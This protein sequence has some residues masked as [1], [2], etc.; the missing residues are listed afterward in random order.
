[1]SYFISHG[2]PTLAIENNDYTQFLQKLG[3]EIGKPKAIVLF[4]AHWENDVATISSI[5]NTYET[6][7]DFGGFSEELYA[8]KYPAKGSTEVASQLQ[9][10]LKVNGI[11]S[12]LDT[13]RG[14]EELEKKHQNCYIVATN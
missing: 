6:I 10:M 1:M 4:T 11:A 3:Q 13:K 2:A 12:Q 5:D 9:E 7:Y 14:L 8:I